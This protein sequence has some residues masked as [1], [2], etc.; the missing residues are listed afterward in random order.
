MAKCITSGSV[1]A[2]LVFPDSISAPDVSYPLTF[3]VSYAVCSVDDMTLKKYGNIRVTAASGSTVN[4]LVASI[5]AQ[6][7][8]NEGIS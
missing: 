1:S 7:K 4:S 5:E 3:E 2:A 6:I 8:A